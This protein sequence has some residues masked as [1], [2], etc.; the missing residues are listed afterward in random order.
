MPSCLA[1]R[2]ALG[3]LLAAS[4]VSLNGCWTAPVAAL[5]QTG[6]ARAEPRLIQ[7]GVAVQSVTDE[8][9]VR[10]VDAAARTIVVMDLGNHGQTSYRAGPDV[11]NL[12][13]IKPGDRIRATVAQRLTVL[14]SSG[15][16]RAGEEAGSCLEVDAKVLTV[17]PSYRLLTLQYPDGRRETFKVGMDVRLRQMEPGDD[18]LI[19]TVDT[20]A[21]QVRGR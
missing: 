17:E 13:R 6:Q 18:V 1:K 21:L 4:A 10:S 15:S 20:L 8:L 11:S 9:V 3:A 16:P 2:A 5:R 19:R 7:E 12:D 14:V